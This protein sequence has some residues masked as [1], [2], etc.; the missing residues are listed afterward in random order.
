MLDFG[1]SVEI[2]LDASFILDS[3]PLHLFTHF[4]QIYEIKYLSILYNKN[5]PFLATKAI[6]SIALVAG[7]GNQN[8]LR[9]F[10]F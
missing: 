3:V 10:L 2:P 7:K 1:G 6:Y 4:D 8:L 9:P 5:N